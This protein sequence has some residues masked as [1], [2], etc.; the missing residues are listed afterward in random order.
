[1]P[2]RLPSPKR[3]MYL[4]RKRSRAWLVVFAAA[5]V[6]G[7]AF[8]AFPG[9]GGEGERPP[10]LSARV[11][12]GQGAPAGGE[13]PAA[14]SPSVGRPAGSDEARARIERARESGD[15]V[16]LWRVLGGEVLD[17]AWTGAEQEEL[18]SE[19]EAAAARA[20][21]SPE[22]ASGFGQTAVGPKET[23][24]HLVRRIRREHG[25]A[26]SPGLLAAVNGIDPLRLREGR[27]IKFPLEDVS[28]VVEKSRFRLHLL[29]GGCV[30]KSFRVGLGRDDRTPEGVFTV[31]AKTENPDW[32]DPR[33]GRLFKFGEDGHLIGTR[34]LG[35]AKE[36]RTTHFGIHGTVEP[37]SIGQAMSDGC[38]RMLNRDVEALFELIHDG[39][40]VVLRP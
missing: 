4:R 16:R 23:Y 20:V 24:W 21:F 36:G 27:P 19:L 39:A 9:G 28:L 31:T 3:S 35:F 18:L 14:D 38:V 6:A 2:L 37:D 10:A 8:W 7:G 32:R 34:W 40:T 26:L 17:P 1:M 11:P 5:A 13:P 29:I 30:A 15:E 33:S 25:V 22:P 12:A